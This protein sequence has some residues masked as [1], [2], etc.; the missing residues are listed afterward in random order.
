VSPELEKKLFEKY[1]KIFADANKSP[2]ESCMAFG[3]E[4]GDGWYNLIDI[5]CEA[6]TY[7]FTTSIEVDEED[8]KRLGLEANRWKND[9]KDRYF[10]KVEAPQVVASQVK[11][12][13]GTLRF[14]YHLKF[15]EANTSL[16]ATKKYPDLEKINRRYCDYI[17]G[18]IHFADIASAHVCEVSGEKGELMVRG[19][20]FKTFSQK[21]VNESQKLD[22]YKPYIAPEI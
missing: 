2:Q 10:F 11:E 13:F 4:V 20:C 12:K 22:G 5:L 17:D 18:I 6:L 16:A 19:G 3:L 9:D 7:T 8:G 1:P 14:Y 15:D 21:V